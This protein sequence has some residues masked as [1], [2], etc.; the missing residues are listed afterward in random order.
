MSGQRW[1]A[2][3]ADLF[4]KPFIHDLYERFG[5]AGVG[6]WIAFLCA[7]KQSRTPGQIRV[8]NDVQAMSE[9]GIL[10]WDLVDG[11]GEPWTM[12]EFWEF[13]GRK[14]QTRRTLVGRTRDVRRTSDGRATDVRATH[15]ERWQERYATSRERERKRTS[16]AQKRPDGGGTSTGH[17]ADTTR[18]NVRRDRDSDSD[19]PPTPLE[20]G[21]DALRAE[22]QKQTPQNLRAG[23][24]AVVASMPPPP[25]PPAKNLGV[26]G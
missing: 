6:V 22:D 13:T 24:G 16:R 3:D 11:K 25:P 21:R 2:L 19:N 9:L 5:W 26:T 18:T 4:G 8:T 10:G 17:Y 15:W 7:C 23:L 12:S 1:L 14:K 20:G